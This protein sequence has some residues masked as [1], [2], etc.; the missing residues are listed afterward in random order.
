MQ[1]QDNANK[2]LTTLLRA[3]REGS[4]SAFDEAIERGYEELKRVAATRLRLSGGVAT[5]SPTELL[6][7]AVLRILPGTMDFKNRAHFFATI[8]LTV[9]SI[10]VDHA[11][12]RSA[13]KRGGGLL[14]VTLTD[15][16]QGEDSL[17]ADLL[18]LEQALQ[19]LEALDPRAAEV[20]HLTFYGGMSREDIAELLQIS[21]TTVRRDLRFARSWLDK[22]LRP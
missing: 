4:G 1:P 2:D 14:Q 9:R 3:W 16:E 10:L 17:A 13:Q 22:T 6:H 18:A 21:E 19:Q 15:V 5:L 7:E 12:A 8:S 20:M 11:R